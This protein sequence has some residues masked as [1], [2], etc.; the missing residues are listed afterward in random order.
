MPPR[1]SFLTAPV[2]LSDRPRRRPG[3]S[4]GRRG[5]REKRARGGG[6]V[7]VRCLVSL[8][9]NDP[10]SRQRSLKAAYQ[11]HTGNERSAGSPSYCPA[12]GSL[13]RLQP[14]SARPPSRSAFDTSIHRHHQYIINTLLF[15]SVILS[16]HIASVP[17]IGIALREGTEKGLDLSTL[18]IRSGG[19]K[20]LPERHCPAFARCAPLQGGKMLAVVI[21]L[22]VL[23]GMLLTATPTLPASDNLM[24]PVG[25]YLS[26]EADEDDA[27]GTLL[28][29]ALVLLSIP[30]VRWGLLPVPCEL[31]M[32]RSVYRSDWERP[33]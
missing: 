12:L 10:C 5:R 29:C 32:L 26:A 22:V 17:R 28:F 4:E 6:S 2:R 24:L 11:L 3:R 14:F 1:A 31:P 21:V 8:R 19:S 23:A 16:A 7:L 18:A 25:S 9:A 15:V 27:S 20:L 33:G 13:S 30:P